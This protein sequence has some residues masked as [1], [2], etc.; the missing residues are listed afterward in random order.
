M[1][2]RVFTNYTYCL[3]ISNASMYLIGLTEEVFFKVLWDTTVGQLEGQT[4]FEG[5]VQLLT[6]NS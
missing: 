1:L 4:L 2:L 3:L 6:A 5:G